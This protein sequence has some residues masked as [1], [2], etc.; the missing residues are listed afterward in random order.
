MYAEFKQK[1]PEKSNTIFNSIMLGHVNQEGK[2]LKVFDGLLYIKV[3]EIAIP[4]N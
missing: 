4:R 3:N 2:W 1:N